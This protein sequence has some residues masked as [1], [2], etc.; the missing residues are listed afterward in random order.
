VF[1]NGGGQRGQALQLLRAKQLPA[2]FDAIRTAVSDKGEHRRLPAQLG[3]A[4]MAVGGGDNNNF[5]FH[6]VTPALT[7]ALTLDG[8]GS[9][10]KFAISKA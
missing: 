9:K 7:L 2:D 5:S 6:L 3:Q 8:T 1:R 4:V 10:E